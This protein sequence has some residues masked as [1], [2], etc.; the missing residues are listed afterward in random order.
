MAATDLSG[1]N[2]SDNPDDADNPERRSPLPDAAAVDEAIEQHLAKWD[3]ARALKAAANLEEA[4]LSAKADLE[5][6]AVV[7]S[8]PA[9]GIELVME[10]QSAIDVVLRMIAAIDEIQQQRDQSRSST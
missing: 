7:L 9:Q 8:A 2:P 6:G 1:R 5:I 10:L 3:V 4:G